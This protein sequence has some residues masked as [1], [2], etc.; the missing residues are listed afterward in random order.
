MGCRSAVKSKERAV[1]LLLHF[2]LNI[3]IDPNATQTKIA[4][5]AENSSVFKIEKI[6]GCLSLYEPRLSTVL[7]EF[8][9][10]VL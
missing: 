3:S 2:A 1:D 4:E 9:E 7:L 5:I 6:L 8:V 10:F